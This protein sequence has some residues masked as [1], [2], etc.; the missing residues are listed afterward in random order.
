MEFNTRYKHTRIPG[1]KCED[2]SL[3][4]PQ[5]QAEC[6]VNN[7]LARYKNVDLIPATRR[8]PPIFGDFSDPAIADYHQAVNV[9]QGV[10]DLMQTLPAKVRARF[11][12]DPTQILAFVA[13][14]DNQAE[15][16]ELGL[17]RP[18]Y[19]SPTKP[20]VGT[21]PPTTPPAPTGTNP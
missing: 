13:N 14:K 4:Q 10:G 17:L 21:T 2:P 15:A 9:I 20:P 16:E 6:D 7:I 12:N 18:D 19:V 1:T 5:F 11:N 8:E 3:T